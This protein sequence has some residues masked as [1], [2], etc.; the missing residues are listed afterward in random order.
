M[1]D[2]I[3][4]IKNRKCKCLACK[5]KKKEYN[6]A[7]GQ[8]NK[9][10]IREKRREY[11]AKNR[12]SIDA[13]M[14]QY[15]KA[16]KENLSEWGKR[17]RQENADRINAQRL[18][19]RKANKA[20]IN[21]RQKDYYERNKDDRLAYAKHF[22]DEKMHPIYKTYDGMKQRCYNPNN[23]GYPN[24]GGRG[25]TICDRWLE[26][27]D[28]FVEDMYPSYQ[29]GL[30]IE[31]NDFNGNYELDNCCWI[32]MSEQGK[33]T[34]KSIEYRLGIPEDSPLSYLDRTMTLKEFSELTNIP[35]IVCKYRWGRHPFCT[36]WILDPTVDNRHYEY[37]GHMYNIPELSLISG[38]K[39][40]VINSRI[41][42]LNWSIEKSIEV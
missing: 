22:R 41:N 30:S 16:N 7:Y 42:V 26:S 38:I 25:I 33:N 37:N 5:Q 2:D 34:R 1:S 4:C 32:P 19:Y 8:L 20:A 39:G 31:R 13:Y 14:S 27:F 28:N 9:A 40:S 18:E 6:K 29:K 10:K 17:H 24:Y 35:L 12:E 15:R 11:V 3:V 21:D 36:D 23:K